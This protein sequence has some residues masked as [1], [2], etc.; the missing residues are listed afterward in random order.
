MIEGIRRVSL[1]VPDLAA[2]SAWYSEF[3]QSPPCLRD[4]VSVSFVL[5]GFWVTLRTGEPPANGTVAYWAVDDIAAE[6]ERALQLGAQPHA[7]VEVVDRYTRQAGVVDPFGNILGMIERD[8]PRERQARSQRSAEKIAL[9][10]IRT[11]LD[12]V[13]SEQA[14]ERKVRRIFWSLTSAIVL[15]GLALVWFVEP[16]KPAQPVDW[17]RGQ[18]A[19]ATGSGR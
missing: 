2:G 16:R 19:P 6:F 7:G 4:E 13:A 18:A 11:T 3:L 14:D 17:V 5:G 10:N 1:L 8:D 15:A 12:H 9:R